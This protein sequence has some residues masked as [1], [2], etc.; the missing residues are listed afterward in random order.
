MADSGFG[1]Y[2]E[3]RLWA[4]RLLCRA[5]FAHVPRRLYR[6]RIRDDPRSLVQGWQARERE[7]RLAGWTDHSARCLRVLADADTGDEDRVRLVLLQTV[8]ALDSGVGAS[9][10]R[11]PND[12][13][14]RAELLML[15]TLVA[16]SLGI[17]ELSSESLRSLWDDDSLW[18]AAAS[19]GEP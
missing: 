2:G 1:G 14:R 3:P 13:Q 12:E 19:I 15:A 7:E 4:L 16:R 11:R 17:G 10:R 18:R 5:P 6:R 9:S 8:A